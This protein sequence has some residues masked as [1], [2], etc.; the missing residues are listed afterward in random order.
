VYVSHTYHDIEISSFCTMYK[1][2]VSTGF[3]EQIMHILRILCY[4]GSLVTWTVVSLTTAK[5]KP[6]IFS[7]SGFT[8][9]N[10]TNMFVLMILYDFCLLPAQFCYIIIHIWKVESR[11][12]IALLLTYRHWRR[13]KHRSSVPVHGPLPSC[14][15]RGRYPATDLHVM[16][17]W[18]LQLLWSSWQL[19]QDSGTSIVRTAGREHAKP[20]FTQILNSIGQGRV[21][22]SGMWRRVVR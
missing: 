8:L 2:S 20:D 1:S 19:L 9:S 11:V 7:M 16:I 17:F 12:Q 21:L 18:L 10:T 15:F 22:S 6:L 3:I 5:F 4:N 13:R 14:L